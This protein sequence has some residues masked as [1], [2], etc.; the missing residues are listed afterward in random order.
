MNMLFLSE[1]STLI[2]HQSVSEM[3]FPGSQTYDTGFSIMIISTEEGE[4]EV[5]ASCGSRIFHSI[6]SVSQIFPE[7]AEGEMELLSV[8]FL[9]T[10]DSVKDPG[11]AGQ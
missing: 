9:R 10:V 5:G 3:F 2:H 7:R 1:M 8:P 4:I 6:P 11:D